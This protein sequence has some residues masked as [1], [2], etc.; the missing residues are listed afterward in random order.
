VLQQTSDTL[1]R[2]G[3][4]GQEITAHL[5]ASAVLKALDRH[6]HGLLDANHFSVYLFHS[7]ELTLVMAFGVEAS[8]P[9]PATHVSLSDP[10]AY[11]ARCVRERREI[12][13]DFDEA[14]DNRN[15]IPGTAPML[16]QLF[17]PLII[18]DRV[19]GV[20][21][22][23]SPRRH[24]YGEREQLIFRT[25]CAY[26]A[27]ALDNAATYRE[28]EATL[29]TLSETKAQLEEA[30]I[31]DSLTGMRNRRFLLQ[32]IESDLAT[33]LRRHDDRMHNGC[34]DLDPNIDMVFF[35]VDL[36]HFKQV[37][38]TYGHAGGDMVLVQ[39]RQRLEE[40]FRHADHIVRWGGEEFLVVARNTSRDEATILAERVR[41]AVAERAFELADGVQLYRTC[42]IGFAC[43]PFLPGEPRRLSWSQVVELADQCLYMVKHTGRDGWAGVFANDRPQPA[44]IV[45]KLMSELHKAIRDGD[46]SV[47]TRKACDMP[48]PDPKILV[49]NKS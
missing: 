24:A 5:D 36:D 43:F 7:D 19:L 49:D 26:G 27:I 9:V 29:N 2:L 25:L 48:Q 37:N 38:D 35:M 33:T 8:K 10:S 39:M 15:T 31:T 45:Q 20:M 13:V 6:V 47:V 41:T 34:G 3:A 18:G 32:H 22:I 23:Q 1:E 28:L 16:S 11:S 12:L 44:N 14:T 4:I 42:S 21:T 30:S 17:A 46:V 40:V